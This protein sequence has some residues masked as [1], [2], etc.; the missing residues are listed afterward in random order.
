[1]K[2]LLISFVL[3]VSFPSFAKEITIMGMPVRASI[4][5]LQADVRAIKD[6]R[7]TAYVSLALVFERTKKGQKV[8]SQLEKSAEAAKKKLHAK[9]LAFKKEEEALKKEAPLLSE[10]AR[11]E[12]VQK[13]QEK[14]VDYQREKQ[15]KELELQNLQT[16][17]M[18]PVFE[19]IKRVAGEVAKKEGYSLVENI[20]NDILWVD[21]SLN[22]TKQVIVQFNKKYK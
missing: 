4:Q 15:S 18:N 20:G 7:K 16:R 1:M 22:L 14:Y 11:M 21:S 3:F 2:L 13:L 12:R 17:L 10:Q 5:K 19:Q 8:K 6:S 9:E